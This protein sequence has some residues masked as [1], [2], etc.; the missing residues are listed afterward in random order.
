MSLR[1]RRVNINATSLS[2][3]KPVAIL[4]WCQAPFAALPR[5][6]SSFPTLH[7]RLIQFQM[8]ELPF[9]S[10][11]VRPGASLDTVRTDDGDAAALSVRGRFRNHNCRGDFFGIGP[12]A[13]TDTPF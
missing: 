8:Y 5:L 4:C 12:V 1:A 9:S 11:Q 10:E 7:V 3:P 6:A 13:S 2:M